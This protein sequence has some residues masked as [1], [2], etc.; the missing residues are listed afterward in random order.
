MA[1]E[2]EIVVEVLS[3]IDEP[4]YTY[5]FDRAIF[6]LNDQIDLL[7]SK[8]DTLDYIVSAASGLLCAAIDILWAGEFDLSCGRDFASDKVDGLV[9]ETAKLM[10]CKDGNVKDYVK[11]L[12][13]KFSIPTDGIPWILAVACSIIYAI[14][15]IIRQLWA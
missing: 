10:G 5:D 12:E 14:L 11:F 8:A 2:N 6:D 4:Q 13:D 3:T 9:E 1:N 15:L 7:T